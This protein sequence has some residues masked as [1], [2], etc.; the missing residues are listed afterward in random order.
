MQKTSLS[1]L[2]LNQGISTLY[3]NEN[4]RV[5]EIQNSVGLTCNRALYDKPLHILYNNKA[6]PVNHKSDIQKCPGIEKVTFEKE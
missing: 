1:E 4:L 6:T 3:C 2:C 5:Y